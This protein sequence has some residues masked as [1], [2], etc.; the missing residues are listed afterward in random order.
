[1]ARRE[2]TRDEL[3]LA[4]N[5]Y[6]QLPFGKLHKGNPEIISLAAAIDR[7]P[8]S[9]AMK[10]CN[11]ASLDPE[12]RKRGVKGLSSASKGDRA[13]WKEFHDDWEQLSSESEALREK[14]GLK[15]VDSESFV[16]ASIGTFV[17]ETD[18]TAIVKVRCAAFLP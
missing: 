9:I 6:C 12:H 15:S 13:I 16:D 3:M 2:W 7:T 18:S 1:M 4:M 17:G 14:L 10:L 11:F 5:L 8:S